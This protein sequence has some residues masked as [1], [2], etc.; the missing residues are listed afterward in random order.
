MSL[1]LHYT[2]II[3]YIDKLIHFLILKSQKHYTDWIKSKCLILDILLIMSDYFKNHP[4]Y[5]EAWKNRKKV[6]N[7]CYLQY[8]KDLKKYLWKLKNSKVLEIG[9]W[10]WKFAYFCS[11][12]WNNDY[13]WIDIDDYFFEK[14]KQDFPNYQFNHVSFQ[15]YLNKHKN[16]FDIIFVS[17][18]FEHLDEIERLEMIEYIYNWLKD[19]WIWINYMPNADAI[20]LSSNWRYT[21]ITHKT[22]YNENSFFQIINSTNCDFL[23]E[24]FNIYIWVKNQ[25]RRLIHLLFRWITK[26]YFLG[27][28]QRFPK[29][30][31][32][33][34]INVLTK[35]WKN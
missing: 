8:K 15:K 14:N 27:M 25:F 9:S 31:T 34:F 35:K 32:W 26:I 3:H 33:E 10:M 28:W 19:N 6:F 29:I 1:V 18:V 21:D 2:K 24:N 11:V 16:E 7:F 13:V 12:I 22:I 23:I 20:L 17:H 5:S 4:C 30:Y